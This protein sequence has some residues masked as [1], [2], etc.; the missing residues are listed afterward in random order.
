MKYKILKFKQKIKKFYY[1]IFGRLFFYFESRKR[2]KHNKIRRQYKL[3]QS[4][5]KLESALNQIKYPENEFNKVMSMILSDI[6]LFGYI[7]YRFYCDRRQLRNITISDNFLRF[8]HPKSKIYQGHPN[9]PDT[10]RAIKVDAQSLFVFGM[11]LINR[12]LL[13]LK[14]YLPDKESDKKYPMYSKIGNFYFS[15]IKSKNLSTPAGKLKTKSLAR[16]KWLYSVLRFYRNEFIEHLDEGYQQGMN[17]GIHT[18]DFALSSYKWN[19]SDDD[20]TL[21]EKFRKK[22]EAKSIKIAGRSNG[23][24]SLINRYYVQRLFDNIVLVPDELL[25]EALNLIEY[26]GVNSPQPTKVIGEVESY[27]EDLFQFMIDELDSSEL[28]KYK[29]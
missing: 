16:I 6:E 25:K 19:Y 27:I 24:R 14:M 21:I 1:K 18:D 20:D 23:G 13:L 28:A 4:F 17:Y 26:I 2:W 12:S 9:Q 11:I 5:R 8:L 7:G 22:M 10:N 15:L 3:V 29:E